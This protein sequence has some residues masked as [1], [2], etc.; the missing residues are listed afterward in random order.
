M[1]APL[2]RIVSVCA[3]WIKSRLNQVVHHLLTWANWVPPKLRKPPRLPM[4]MKAVMGTRLYRTA[5]RRRTDSCVG[6]PSAGNACCC[7]KRRSAER[8]LG[9]KSPSVSSL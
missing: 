3:K 7:W 6:C 9:P 4:P 2:K 1:F 5:C 8:V